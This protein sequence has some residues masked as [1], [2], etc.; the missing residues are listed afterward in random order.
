MRGVT[1][2]CLDICVVALVVW[3]VC[4]SSAWSDDKSAG[5]L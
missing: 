1:G 4:L 3:N 2:V 5:M